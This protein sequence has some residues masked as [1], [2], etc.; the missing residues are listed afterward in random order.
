MNAA[1]LPS[2]FV[3]TL[4]MMVGLFFFIRASVKDRTQE[5]QLV[6]EQTE[7][8]LLARL[9]QYF[10]QR[11]YRVTAVDAA[12]NQ[13]TFQGVVRPSVFLAIFLSGLAAAGLL[14]LGLVLSMVWANFTQGLLALALLSPLAGIFYWQRAKRPEQV[15]LKV[16]ALSTETTHP[17]SRIT[18]IAHRDEVAELQRSLDLKACE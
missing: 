9:Q 13:V 1:I 17:Q 12:Q 8:S 2:I 7:D 10:D 16:E 15:S 11:A 5:V 6:A 14:C 18:V 4:L 3:M